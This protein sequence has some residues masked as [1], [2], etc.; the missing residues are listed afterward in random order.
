MIENYHDRKI[1]NKLTDSPENIWDKNDERNQ[2]FVLNKEAIWIT[3]HHIL[4]K[5]INK[6][7]HKLHNNYRII[8][9]ENVKNNCWLFYDVDGDIEFSEYH[10]SLI[11]DVMFMDMLP[12]ILNILAK[13]A[14]LPFRS[15]KLLI[16]ISY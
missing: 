13:A 10:Q 2:C 3:N 14:K 12:L 15:A 8:D 11:K 16:E 4:D 5:I 7:F 9:N 1:I 6:H